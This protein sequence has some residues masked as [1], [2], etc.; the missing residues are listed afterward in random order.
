MTARVRAMFGRM[1]AAFVGEFPHVQQA[2]LHLVARQCPDG[3]GDCAGRDLAWMTDDGSIYLLR[4]AMDRSDDV[5][6][7][8]L[9]HE[10]GHL[11][12]VRRWA[13]GSERRADALAERALGRRIRYTVRDS[14]QTF[15]RGI[16]PRPP[17]LHT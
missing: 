12:D 11:A 4:R 14:L 6:A 17:W 2:R 8:L 3:G 10:L 16:W 13:P 1:R 9:A 15:G 7:A 5:V